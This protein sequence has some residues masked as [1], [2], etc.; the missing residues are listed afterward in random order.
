MSPVDAVGRDWHVELAVENVQYGVSG[1]FIC[2]RD[3]MHN[4]AITPAVLFHCIERV[5]LVALCCRHTGHRLDARLTLQRAKI[6]RYPGTG[7]V[8]ILFD[9]V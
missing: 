5:L 8:D 7:V 1:V 4:E 3:A 6:S 2:L 9:F